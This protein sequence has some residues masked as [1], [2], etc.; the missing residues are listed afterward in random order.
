MKRRCILVSR[1]EPTSASAPFAMTSIDSSQSLWRPESSSPLRSLEHSS[2]KRLHDRVTSALRSSCSPSELP[3]SSHSISS[4]SD[5]G[6]FRIDPDLPL[7]SASIVAKVAASSSLKRKTDGQK[8]CSRSFLSSISTFSFQ[9]QSK[10]TSAC[11][12]YSFRQFSEKLRIFVPTI[13]IF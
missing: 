7:L 8:Y 13:I 12:L 3:L 11:A 4:W 10:Y 1:M 2:L 9:K 5:L 6:G